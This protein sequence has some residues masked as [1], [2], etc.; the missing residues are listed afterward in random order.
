MNDGDGEGNAY[1][2]ASTYEIAFRWIKNSQ[3]DAINNRKKQ[4]WTEK[5]LKISIQYFED[6]KELHPYDIQ[7]MEL[8]EE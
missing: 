6:P 2:A 7:E 4:G 5:Q 3:L 8:D 1:F